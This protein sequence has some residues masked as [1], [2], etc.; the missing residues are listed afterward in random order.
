VALPHKKCSDDFLSKS[1]IA[2]IATVDSAQV[3]L[4]FWPHAWRPARIRAAW[5]RS[6]PERTPTTGPRR[7]SRSTKYQASGVMRPLMI[8]RII[9]GLA[10][11]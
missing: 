1:L 6:K 3:G 7:R 4:I 10:S 5:R 9:G 11:G 8:F 2:L